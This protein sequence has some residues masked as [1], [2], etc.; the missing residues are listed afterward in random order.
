MSVEKWAK[1]MNEQV[2]KGER[3][4]REKENR[5]K[6]KKTFNQSVNKNL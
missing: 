3:R 6:G 2:I 4:E 1:D 5:E